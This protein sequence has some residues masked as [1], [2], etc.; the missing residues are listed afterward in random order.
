MNFALLMSQMEG[1]CPVDYNTITN[2]FLQVQLLSFLYNSGVG[3][4]DVLHLNFTPLLSVPLYIVEK[5][6]P[7]GNSVS[8]GCPEAKFTRECFPSNEGDVLSEAMFYTY[9]KICM[10]SY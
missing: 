7:S 10:A 2:L 8:A 4:F 9:V 5:H 1:R 6:D 3:Q